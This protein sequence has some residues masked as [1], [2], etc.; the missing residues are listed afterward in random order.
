MSYKDYLMANWEEEQKKHD[1]VSEDWK[2]HYKIPE[3]RINPYTGIP[4][5]DPVLCLTHDQLDN[6]ISLDNRCCE[7]YKSL[8][9]DLKTITNDI[10]NILHKVVKHTQQLIL[11]GVFIGNRIV[12]TKH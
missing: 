8:T 9:D 4:T 1:R 5:S 3:D 2:K 7:L 11:K 10:K 12:K 6:I